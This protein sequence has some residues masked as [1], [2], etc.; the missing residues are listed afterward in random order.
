LRVH[1]FL[2]AAMLTL[3]PFAALPAEA[4]TV[5]LACS[6]SAGQPP[7]LF[8]KIDFEHAA[9][10]SNFGT[11]T[12]TITANRISWVEFARNDGQGFS[13]PA[14]TFALDR[15]TG[16][17]TGDGGNAVISAVCQRGEKPGPV[18]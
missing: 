15:N 4:E 10:T 6:Y 17:L 5:S 14:I 16:V 12:A 18:L 8:L 13:R 7:A 2:A 3:A 1:S 9:V 11:F